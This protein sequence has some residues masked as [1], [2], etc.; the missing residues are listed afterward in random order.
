MTPTEI[1]QYNASYFGIPVERMTEHNALMKMYM[2]AWPQELKDFCQE[3]F[4][5]IGFCGDV[6][7]CAVADWLKTQPVREYTFTAEDKAMYDERAKH[8]NDSK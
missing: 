4:N 6:C 2:S 7:A 3:V 5:R 1:N 8:A